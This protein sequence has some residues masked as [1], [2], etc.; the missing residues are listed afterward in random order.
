MPP[1]GTGRGNAV[2]SPSQTIAFPRGSSQWY[3]SWRPS[4]PRE[5]HVA[6][7]AFSSTTFAARAGAGPEWPEPQIPPDGCER[8]HGARVYERPRLRSVRDGSAPRPRDAPRA[9]RAHSRVVHAPGRPVA[10]RVPRDSR[11][12]RVLRGRAHAGALRGGH[13]PA[14]PSARGGR[15]GDVRGHHDPGARHGHRRRPRRGRRAG[16]RAARPNRGR[17][18]AVARA[19]SGGGVRAR[20]RG[21][22]ARPR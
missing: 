18:R 12:A 21:G 3:E 19:R 17:R 2:R 11:A 1:G 7:P 10:A 16:R 6:P 13:P 5:R 15:C 4:S 20:A 9:R 22:A 14:R 8:L